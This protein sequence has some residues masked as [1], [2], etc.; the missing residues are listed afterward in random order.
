MR[1]ATAVIMAAIALPALS[2]QSG[3]PTQ[4]RQPIRVGTNFVRVD[5]YP[6]KDGQIVT[7]LQASDFEVLEDGVPQKVE[8]FEHVI[9]AAGPYEARVEPGSQR[10]MVRALA[11]PRSR[12]FLIFLDGPNVDRDGSRAINDPIIRFLKEHL[13]DEDLVGVMTPGMSASQVAF[14]RRTDVIE[15]AFRTKWDWGRRTH[16]LDPELDQRLIQYSLCYPATDIGG[17]MMDRARE[18]VTLE[19]LQ[20]AVKFLHNV[21]EER[22]AIVT[23]TQGWPLYREDPDLMRKRD[24]ELPIGVDPIRPGPNGKLTA[25]DKRNTV[26]AL[27]PNQCDNDRAFLA[28]IDD[29][30]FL[31]EIIEDANRGNASFYMIDPGGL[32]VERA[33]DR[34]GA[35]RTLAENTDGLTLLNTNALDVGFRRIAADMSSYYLLG[36]Y[37]TNTKPDGRFRTVTVRVKQAGVAVRA[38]KGYRA[39]TEEEL[40]AARVTAPASPA[41]DTAAPV[42]AALDTLARI[43]PDARFHVSAASSLSGRASLWV[44]GEIQPAAGRPVELTQGWRVA[45]EA[46]GKGISTSATVVLKPGERT[47]LARLDL[48]AGASG[49]VDV[50]AQLSSAD[51]TAASMS[52]ASRMTVGPAE[53]QA[54][55][56]R[57]GV[58]TGNRFLPAA[59]PRFSRTE[60]MRIEIPVA[61]VKPGAG[62][63]LDRAGQPLQVPVATGERLDAASGQVW[64]TAD[65]NLAALSPGDYVIEVALQ[66]A[67]EPRTLIA[68]RVT[69]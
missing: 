46:V 25:E 16:E 51:G 15:S 31:R 65:V 67:T 41:P 55:L 8:M 30:K 28:S 57:R 48:P 10:E 4:S 54:V 26:N 22:K 20:D 32:R 19:A 47:F 23:I 33:A 37:A 7:G 56:F 44:V 3:N 29:E 49:Q 68:I 61:D 12:V 14:G 2:A 17:K 53:I 18:R 34:S 42:A 38:R 69:R 6:T 50:R 66:G 24:R 64:I 5:V 1:V 35:M 40:A 9:A 45:I 13:A 43:R 60:R 58:T 36:Y 62:R 59:D 11:N 39:P 21:R 27:P 63:M 52:G